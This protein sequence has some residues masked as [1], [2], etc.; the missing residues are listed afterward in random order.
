MQESE[1]KKTNEIKYTPSQEEAIFLRNKNILVSAG[2]GSG[3]TFVMTQRIVNLIKEGLAEADEI[4]VVTF[5]KAA[6]AQMR[7]R[8]RSA[9]IKE[10]K[11]TNDERLFKQ[12]IKLESA[13]IS[14]VHALC[15]AII[16]I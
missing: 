4:L 9:L 7:S 5:T 15:S 12:V 1:I 13:Q 6:A 10:A 11:A 2:A 8:I 16:K 14:T 3:K